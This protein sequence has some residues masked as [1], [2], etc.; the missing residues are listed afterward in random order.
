MPTM[1]QKKKL[2]ILL[3]AG[4]SIKQGLPCSMMLGN[5]IARWAANHASL[6]K[7]P[8]YYQLLLENR[9]DYYENSPNFIREINGVRVS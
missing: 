8:D 4:S 5:Q 3:G 6:N 7:K 2:L 9:N 1:P